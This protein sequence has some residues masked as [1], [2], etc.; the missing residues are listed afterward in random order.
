MS[1]EDHFSIDD[2]ESF[3]E[4]LRETFDSL[5]ESDPGSYH[6]MQLQLAK[7]ISLLRHK[8]VAKIV[9]IPKVSSEAPES[10]EDLKN[11]LLNKLEFLKNQLE[12]ENIVHSRKFRLLMQIA[13]L[14]SQ[15]VSLLNHENK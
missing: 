2:I 14:R 1:E 13:K 5:N 15:I 12:S 10:T 7:A 6:G 9:Q 8:K 3:I 4:G 11:F